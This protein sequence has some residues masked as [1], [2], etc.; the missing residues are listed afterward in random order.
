MHEACIQLEHLEQSGINTAKKSGNSGAYICS[1]KLQ[2]GR[3]HK[4]HD[5]T[6]LLHLC[7][8]V[9]TVWCTI[10]RG[11]VAPSSEKFA[12]LWYIGQAICMYSTLAGMYQLYYWYF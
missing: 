4:Q 1:H 6:A 9:S 2:I 8:M 11:Q 10:P 7:S 3:K 12:Y 5:R